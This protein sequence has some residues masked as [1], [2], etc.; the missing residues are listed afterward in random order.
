MISLQ[1]DRIILGSATTGAVRLK[2]RRKIGK[3]Y[4]FSVNAFDNR[5]WFAPFP[6]FHSDLHGL[7]LHAD[8]AA[9]TQV[10]RQAAGR[11]NIGHS[12]GLELLCGRPRAYV[13]PRTYLRV[14]SS[15]GD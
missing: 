5:S 11:T 1:D 7:L 4:A 12:R 14:P 9:N 13:T 6:H 10:L 8:G 15:G 2:F 3:T